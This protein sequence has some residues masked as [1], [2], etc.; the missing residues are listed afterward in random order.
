MG[1]M[2]YIVLTGKPNRQPALASRPSVLLL[3]LPMVVV[4]MC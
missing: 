1:M 3:L 2:M 4:V